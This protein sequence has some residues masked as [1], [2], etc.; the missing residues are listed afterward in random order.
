MEA[1][2]FNIN[3]FVSTLVTHKSLISP[4]FSLNQVYLTP[5]A[6]CKKKI[7]ASK[8]LNFRMAEPAQNPVLKQRVVIPNKHGEKLVGL[9]HDTG[10][11][12]IV[13]LCHGFLSNKENMTMG[14]LAAALENEGITAFRFDFAGNGESEGSFEYGNYWRE[15]EDL[16]AVVQHFNAANR[17]VRA[18][19]GHSKGGGVVL[20]YASKYNDIGAVVNVSGRYNLERGVKERLGEDFMERLNREGFIDV[21]N[22]SGKTIYRV[23]KESMADRLN[24]NMHEACLNIDKNCRVLT[25]HGTLD[26]IIPV[27]DAIEFSKIIPNHELHTVEG[28]NHGYSSHQ[29]ELA[30][31]VLRFI[32]SAQL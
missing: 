19:L 25:V 10:S 2:I 6:T 17:V 18:V 5:T 24:T 12:E 15:A 28:A 4:G 26:E 30:T 9:L 14:N 20:L 21:K 8:Y 27:E 31:I 22:K 1:L 11:K 16:R 23:T 32:M 3:P 29:A 7:R 13:I